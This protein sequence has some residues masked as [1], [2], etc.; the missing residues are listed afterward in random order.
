MIAR[1]RPIDRD[2]S[3]LWRRGPARRLALALQGG[4]AHGAYTWGVLDRLLELEGL[5]VDAVSGTSAGALNA[6][7]LASGWLAGG[8]AGAR[9]AL[10]AV[11]RSVSSGAGPLIDELSHVRLFAMSLTTHLFSP[12]DLNP[13]DLNPLREVLLREVDFARLR[14]AT[15]PTVLVAATDVQN[16]QPRIFAN[17]EL[18]PEVVLASATLPQLHRAAEIDGRAYWDG[19][20]T[21]N[22]PVLAL[23]ERTRAADLLL[24]RIN[25]RT[26]E[27]VPKRAPAIRNRM[28]EIVFG[29]PLRQELA[30]LEELQALGRRPLGWLDRRLRRLARQRLWIID[31]DDHLS[32]LSPATRLHPDWPLLQQLR[33]AGRV[34]AE[35][36][37]AERGWVA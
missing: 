10:E 20:Y 9:A 14:A 36:W 13:L 26:T 8:P 2:L 12:Y 30:R 5:Q 3:S 24:V 6:V 19:G 37:L 33:D 23:A 22:P 16:A 32:T 17:A 11:W 28:A 18:T 15:A 21:A 27:H 31:G 35:A 34:A 7:A 25:P 4:G 29:E 1:T